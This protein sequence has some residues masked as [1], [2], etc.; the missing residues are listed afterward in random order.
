LKVPEKSIE[1]VEKFGHLGITVT[2]Q[3]HTNEKIKSTLNLRNA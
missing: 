1:K 3:N 2:N